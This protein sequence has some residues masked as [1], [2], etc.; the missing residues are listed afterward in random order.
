MR[1]TY[2]LDTSVLIDSPNAYTKFNDS[3]VIIPI[4][5][6]NELDKLKKQP[7]E[8]GK[9]ARVCIRNLD[10][11]SNLGDINVGILLDNDIL[12]KID[13]EYYNSNSNEHIFGSFGDPGYGDTQILSCA[14][15][16][17]KK[18]GSKDVIL[19]SNDF[20]LK[21]K[22]KARKIGAISFEGDSNLS[23]ELY[24]GMQEIINEKAGLDM[25]IK[26]FAN[27]SDLSLNLFPNQCVL[28]KNEKG[29]SVALGR[30]INGSIK[31]IKKYYPWGI[32]ARNPEQ[33]FLMDMMMDKNLDLI[34]VSG[35]A[36]NGK[37]ITSIATALELVLSKKE[38]NKFI[39]Y[40]PIESVGKELGFLP[41][42]QPL[43]A[44]ILT[45]DGWSIMGEMKVGS[46]ISAKDGSPTKVIGVYPKGTKSV[47]KITTTDG[48]ST[49]CCE[50]HL[51][52]T[53]TYENKKRNKP[54]TI[55][56]TKEIKDTLIKNGKINHYLPRN[57]PIQFNKTEELPLSPYVLGIILGDGSISHNVSFSSM[58]IEIVNRVEKEIKKLGCRVHNNYKN[59]QYS[60]SSNL[61]NNK[62]ASPVKITNINNGEVQ[63]YNSIGIANKISNLHIST[64]RNRCE[65]NI[66][67]DNINYQFLPCEK[68]WQ[69]PVKNILFN[70]GLS[71]KKAWDKF[72]PNQYKYQSSIE[73]RI[74]LLQGLMD[75]DGTI[76]KNGEA[77]YCTTSKQLAL[78]VIEI[79]NSLGGRAILRSRN[80]I[81]KSSIY[82]G[83]TITTKRI[84]Y[85][86]NISLPSE[87]N[88]FYLSRK[89]NRHHC[90]YIYNSKIESIEYVGEKEVQC[91]LIDNPEHLYV[92][93]DY[94]VTHN[95]E[96]EK[97]SPY[98]SAILD[99]FELLLS[100][101]S[102]WK[103]DLELYQ[104]KGRIEFG[105]LSYIRGRSLPNALILIDDAQN[106]SKENM[107][108]ILTRAGEGTKIVCTGDPLQIDNKDLD[109][110]DN[111]FSYVIEKFK[112]SEL[113]GHITFTKGERSKF[114]TLAA[115]IL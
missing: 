34:T 79:V 101:N 10:E 71:K 53:Q 86:F 90:S 104:K 78:D 14:Y 76:K 19:V 99:S 59:I 26:G 68:R 103:R 81:G 64:L 70:L 46:I 4:S 57:G 105:A 95:T 114:A 93:N 44:K 7:N 27:P 22:A 47:Y 52:Y 28:F 35:N 39:I 106:L 82:N 21:I 40:R 24:S 54:G 102:D 3:D 55:K 1:K 96:Q 12:L 9:N 41:G 49:E 23:T 36:G 20:N 29:E 77:M 60:I 84:S 50:D 75:T 16:N 65:N 56:T 5:A 48:T 6:V 11:I 87:I 2:V 88:P 33:S 110:V 113:A 38:Y 89:A 17:W 66:T 98:F 73:D 97:L 72:I 69:N 58:D 32:S 94:I 111:G 61:Y 62:P 115:E 63:I 67:V 108:I 112:D 30:L 109:S 51:W 91:I 15:A 92:T 31:L 13:A 100:K 43:D 74:A 8:V 37:S 25:L 45:P 80:R 85:E 18:H 83:K 42:P 107:K